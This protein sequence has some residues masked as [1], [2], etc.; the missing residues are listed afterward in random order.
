MNQKLFAIF[1]ALILAVSIGMGA[2]IYLQNQKELQQ[3]AN[4]FQ[5]QEESQQQ[6]NTYTVIGNLTYA[7]WSAINPGISV[8]SVSPSLSPYP[9]NLTWSIPNGQGASYNYTVDA[10]IFVSFTGN[11]TF[12]PDS[13]AGIGF[14]TGF[15]END[16][17]K[18]SGEISFNPTSQDYFMNVT[19][20][21]HYNP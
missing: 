15:E 19:N 10:F 14:P 12:P 4:N 16:M 3:Q 20:I 21:S 5:D 18:L 9:S 8:T 13:P 2:G 11:F 7:P 1:L 17:V 6:T